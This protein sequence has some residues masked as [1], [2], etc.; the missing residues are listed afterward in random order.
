VR[1]V[2]LSYRLPREPSTPRIAVW[3]KLRR[4]GAVQV[5]DGLAGLPLNPRNRE[6]LEWLADEVLEAGG[7]SGLWLAEP[8][9]LTQRA[10]ETRMAGEVAEDYQA[11]ITAALDGAG[12]AH[13]QRHRTLDRLRRELH[14]IQA[15]DHF[16]PAEAD[17]ARRAVEALAVDLEVTA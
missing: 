4:L 16:P 14:R 13:G 8:D 11:I 9:A 3:R 15:R 5:L 2:L 7:E 6:R 12:E 17:E 1:W 10:L